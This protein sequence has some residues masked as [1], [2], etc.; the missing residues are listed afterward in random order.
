MFAG[1]CKDGV[2][3][4]EINTAKFP[5]SVVRQK[6]QFTVQIAM[7]SYL[8]RSSCICC[9]LHLSLIGNLFFKCDSDEGYVKLPPIEKE[10]FFI[11]SSDMHGK[12]AGVA[13]SRT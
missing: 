8:L 3:Q 6:T 7:A 2:F 5:N 11:S 12:M 13:S 10:L 9:K 4:S 1:E